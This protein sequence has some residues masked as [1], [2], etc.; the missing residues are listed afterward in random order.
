MQKVLWYSIT[1]ITLAVAVFIFQSGN[2][3]FPNS[4]IESDNIQRVKSMKSG[5]K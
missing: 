1:A 5:G 3:I 2:A 4:K